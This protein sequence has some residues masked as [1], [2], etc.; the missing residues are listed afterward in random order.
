MADYRQKG[1][2]PIQRDFADY[3]TIIR[4]EYGR[5]GRQWAPELRC[6][7]LK[8]SRGEMA[9]HPLL[10]YVEIGFEILLNDVHRWHP[11]EL[12]RKGIPFRSWQNVGFCEAVLDEAS[13]CLD[14]FRAING[15]SAPGRPFRDIR[16]NYLV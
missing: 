2:I 15:K 16:Q 5:N 12:A 13:Q 9:I 3:R 1:P 14:N 8:S 6:R 7:S 11:L 4:L 10:S